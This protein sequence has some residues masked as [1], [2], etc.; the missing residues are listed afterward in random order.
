MLLRFVSE[1][2]EK[3]K[4]KGGDDD[5]EEEEAKYTR[6]WYRPWKKVRVENTNKKVCSASQSL[7]TK[8]GK[9][10]IQIDTA[11]VARDGSYE[12]SKFRGH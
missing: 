1:Q 6:K 10:L 9:K 7:E 3:I 4:R 8:G 2:A 11:R 12:R 5:E